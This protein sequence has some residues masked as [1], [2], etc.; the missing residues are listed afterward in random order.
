MAKLGDVYVAF[1]GDTSGLSKAARD[2]VASMQR[3]QRA[4]QGSNERIAASFSKVNLAAKAAFS[5][6]AAGTLVGGFTGT[7]LA[8]DRVNKALLAVTGSTKLAAAEFEYVKGVANRLGLEVLSTAQQYAFLAA[9]S[10]GTSLEGEQTRKIFEAVATASSRLGLTAD[11]TAGALNAIQQMMSKGKVQAEELRGQLGERLPGAFQMAA[12]AMGVTTGELSKMLDLGQITAD[13]LLPKL[14]DEMLKTGGTSEGLQ[15]AINRLSNSWNELMI[16]VANSGALDAA[17]ATLGVIKSLVDTLTGQGAN[18]GIINGL[19]ASRT[20][21]IGAGD[22]E[23]FNAAKPNLKF[24]VEEP[25]FALKAR[26]KKSSARGAGAKSPEVRAAEEY[27]TSLI[28]LAESLTSRYMPELDRLAK[29]QQELNFLFD[30]G[31]ISLETFSTGTIE[32]QN[33]IQELNPVVDNLKDLWKDMGDASA[34]AFTDIIAGS[35]SARDAIAGLLQDLARMVAQKAIFGP[36]SDA[37]AGGLGSLFGGIS[38]PGRATGGPV[39]ARRPYMV[40]ENGPELFVPSFDGA[41]RPRGSSGG[42]GVVINQTINAPGANPATLA[43][44]RQ[45]IGQSRDEIIRAMPS[46]MVNKQRRSA[47]GGA[48]A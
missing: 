16:S 30:Q 6:F 32:V 42:G 1:G 31:R 19:E 47:L 40:G 34:Q 4:I 9:A 38:I 3:S 7:A 8:F 43:L 48:F 12:R 18:R 23:A 35:A 28:N 27:E 45:M 26:P 13:Q 5:V 21:S 2:A 24:A 29:D 33:R 36:L 46:V 20:L 10:K 17:V 37:I 41:I 25:A 11:Q 14:A 39:S 22:R 15:A 44:M